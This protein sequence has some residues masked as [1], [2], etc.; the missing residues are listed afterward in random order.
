[1]TLLTAI[2]QETLIFYH[3]IAIYLLLGFAIAALLH[4]FFPESLIRRH[5]GQDTFGSVLKA[6]LFGIPLPLCSCGVV[7]V[8]AS[9]KN[10]GA[11]Q[12]A[13]VSFL[14]ATPQIGAD[15]FMITYSLL[16]WVFGLFRIVAALLTALVAGLL[17]N[18]LKR[19]TPSHTDTCPA[20]V[21]NRD[22]ETALD[23]AKQGFSYVEYELL[24]P[25]ANSLLVGIL[26]AGVIGALIPSDFVEGYLGGTFSSMLIMLLLGIPLYVCASASTPIAAALILKGLSP[27]AALVFLLTGP[28]TNAMSIATVTKIVGK[29][30][31][32]IYLATIAAIS[33]LLGLLLN[34]LVAATPLPIITTHQHEILPAWLKLAGSVG[35]TLMLGWYYLKLKVLDKRAGVTVMSENRMSL[36]VAG[37]TCTHCAANVRR[38]I[39]AFT[40]ADINLLGQV[41]TGIQTAGY[42][43]L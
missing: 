26:L 16:G 39:E 18:L 36:N 7:P 25:I 14:I 9:L 37:M 33:L 38:A 41:K 40:L 32:V 35:L 22:Q 6:T 24:G 13:T 43:I 3:E 28:A 5:L 42:E 19:Q 12:G 8:A 34:L 30:A 11:S 23:R 21:P 10:S 29:R 31:T 27:G 17:V 2:A 15:S 4:V 20:P 1:M